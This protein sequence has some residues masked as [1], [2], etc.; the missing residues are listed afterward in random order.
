MR[1]VLFEKTKVRTLETKNKSIKCSI[2]ECLIKKL[3]YMLVIFFIL[4]H[5]KYLARRKLI[6]LLASQYLNSYVAINM[7]CLWP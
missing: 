2:S 1:E 6:S 4:A 5:V 7:P 3:K